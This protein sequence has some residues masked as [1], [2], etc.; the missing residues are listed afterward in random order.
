MTSSPRSEGSA[1]ATPTLHP[2]DVV[3]IDCSDLIAKT[4]QAVGRFGGM[5]VFVWGPIAGERAWVRIESVKPRY[6]VADLVELVTRAPERAEPFCPVFGA[7]GGCQVQHVAYDAQLR[8]KRSLVESAL[9]RI[10]KLQNV[11]VGATV[12]MA[13]P[14]NYR[15][16]MA[17]VVDGAQ[18]PLSFGFYA[19]RTHEVVPLEGCPIVM[20][21]LDAYIRGLN[22][23]AR[24]PESAPAFDGAKHV[25]ART[26]AATGEAVVSVTT[27]RASPVLAQAAEAVAKHLPG[28]VGIANSFEPPSDNAVM[29]RRSATA[30]GRVD[31]DETIAGIRFRVSPASFFQVNGEMV[32]AIFGSMEKL[33]AAAGPKK[34]LD[35]Y[36]GAGTFSLFFA[37]GGAEVAGVEEN[38]NAVREA[39]ANAAI[40]GLEARTSFFSGRVDSV[41]RTPKGKTLLEGAEVV[42]LDPPRKGS[43]EITLAT[44][45]RTRVPRIWYLSCNPATLARDAAQ[46]AAGGYV[47]EGVQPF[48]MFPQ[49]GHV[50]AL[51]VFRRSD[52]PPL[53]FPALE[54][55]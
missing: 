28:V 42:F 35:L 52:V 40:N 3:E 45:N 50:E 15:N 44:L 29:G 25:I 39:R 14:R 2:G 36:C 20:P 18:Q 24:D 9:T 8:W 54:G 47:L 34:V 10:G 7:C 51:A 13:N 49:T 55:D 6:A 31:I 53:L 22:D 41:L 26:A 11:R 5:A 48:D 37:R 19:A 17:L 16:K 1:A 46:L 23:A 33:L 30:F 43:D 38:P 4:G 32:A 21:Q 27:D 12:A